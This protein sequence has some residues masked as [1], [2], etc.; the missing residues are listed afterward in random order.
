MKYSR[1]FFTLVLILSISLPLYAQN[2]LYR[3]HDT[4]YPYYRQADSLIA[5]DE[6][7]ALIDQLMIQAQKV[8]DKK[9]YTLGHTLRLRRAIKNSAENEIITCFNNLREVSTNTGYQQ[10][11]YYAYRLVSAY[12]FNNHEVR[13]GMAYAKKMHEE[14]V[15]KN[16]DY[17]KWYSSSY[18]AYLYLANYQRSAAIQYFEESIDTYN[19]TTDSTIRSQSM[20]KPYL[21]L[22]MLKGKSGSSLQYYIDKEL[23]TARISVDTILVNYSCALMYALNGDSVNYVNYRDICLANKLFKRATNSGKEIFQILDSAVLAGDMTPVNNIIVSLNN[24]HDL[25][26]ISTIA[27]LKNDLYTLR[28]I[29]EIITNKII[30]SYDGQMKIVMKETE[31]MIENEELSLSV[32][33]QKT[34]ANTILTILI[35]FIIVV[36]ILASIVTSINIRKLKQ[37][38]DDADKANRMK[39]YFVQNMSHEIRTPLNAV[40]GYSQLLAL[41][42]GMLEEAE[43]EEYVS[44]INNNSSIL[45]MLIDDILDLSDIDN[46]NYRM[47]ISDCNC[48]DICRM[49]LKTVESRI[50]MDVNAFFTTDAAD[51]FTVKSDQRRIQQILTNFLINASKYTTEGEI[52]LSC[53]LS[54][55]SGYVCFA[56]RDTGSGIPPEKADTIFERFSKLDSFKQGSGLGLSICV[57]I[58]EKLGGTVELDKDYGRVSGKSDKGSRFLLFIPVNN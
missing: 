48:N 54:H 1:L 21:I 4:C 39:T 28:N 7:D 8:N 45:M 22:F 52:E 20:T 56:V 58:S 29:Y 13:K 11:Y 38:K 25:I 24:L 37:A 46:G 14:A 50:P 44:Y 30:T 10:Y 12:Y 51:D 35:L 40:V 32:I 53:S 43:R 27:V 36:I 26:F 47:N 16:S 41:S 42:D 3:I 33:E 55:R 31:V 6:S 17:G 19:N 49:A 34:R 9:A 18:L 23:E 15:E 2:N 5:Y 57:V